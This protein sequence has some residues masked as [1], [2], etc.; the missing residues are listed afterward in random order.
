VKEKWATA[1]AREVGVPTP[2]VLV[3][4]SEAVPN[5]YMIARKSAGEPATRYGD[6]L[7]IVRELGCY[8]AMIHS[9]ETRGFGSTFDWAPAAR[10]RCL[11]WRCF[12]D[13]ELK[14]EEKLE[15]LESQNMITA[16]TRRQI[17][18]VLEN[19][20]PQSTVPRLAHGD[21]RVKNVLIESDARISA[22]LDWENCAPTL[23][24]H[25]EF[26]LALHDLNIDEKQAFIE[27]YGMRF[28]AIEEI[29]PVL[30]AFN[31][32]NY[33]QK[34]EGLVRKKDEHGLAKY[35]VRLNGAFDLYRM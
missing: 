19:A 4:S 26:A 20:E 31:I 24:P 1:K 7:A 5:A 18:N 15:L 17:A 23:A 27:G 28:E 32:V 21:L 25:W 34:V 14:V 8:A 13:E 12:L 3:V 33:A 35:R 9:I 11:D 22:I 16:S 29:A 2:E 30:K 10:P 6:R